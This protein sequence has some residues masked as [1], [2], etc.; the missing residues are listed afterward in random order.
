MNLNGNVA[1]ITGGKR[2][3]V[4]VGRELAPRGVDVAFSYAR[5]Q[6]EAEQAAAIVRGRGPRAAVLQADLVEPPACARAR[7]RRRPRNSA[8]STSSSTWR[9]ST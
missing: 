5:S 3:G 8:D 9:R 4:V 1:L 2:I 7:R 6:A